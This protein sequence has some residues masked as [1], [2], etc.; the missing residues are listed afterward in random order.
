MLVPPGTGGGSITGSGNT[1]VKIYVPAGSQPTVSNPRLPLLTPPPA[2]SGVGAPPAPQAP[3]VPPVSTPPPAPG[4]QT[5]AI[6]VNGPTTINQ[7]ISVGPNSSG[8]APAPG[9][10]SCQ[11][12]LALPA[13]TYVGTVDN[14]AVSFTVTPGANN[15]LNL[16]LGGVPDSI[17][18]VPGSPASAQN[19]QNGIDLY[20]AGKHALLVETLDANQNVMVG[21]SGG[22]FSLNQAGGSLALTVAQVPTWRLPRMPRL[23]RALCARASPSPEITKQS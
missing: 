1:V 12:S 17:A 9:G 21:G 7:T 11:L 15:A 6:S 18:V 16:T 23:P 20:G 2:A 19:A 13:G 22:T 4:S 5:L 14:T 3:A 8:C 10:S